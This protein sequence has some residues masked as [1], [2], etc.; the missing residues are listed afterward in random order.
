MMHTPGPWYTAAVGSGDVYDR[1]VGSPG[2]GP[3]ICRLLG[4]TAEDDDNTRLIAAAPELLEWLK[5]C[6]MEMEG[7]HTQAYPKCSGGCPY[8]YALTGARAA[9]AKAEGR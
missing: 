3:A 5:E 1:A 7:M 2:R 9:I 4:R 6:L 8:H